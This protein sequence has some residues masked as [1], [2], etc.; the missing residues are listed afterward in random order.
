[1]AEVMW[2]TGSGSYSEYEECV[3]KLYD[4]YMDEAGKITEAYMNS[5]QQVLL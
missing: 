2:Y 5:A 1:M 4:V 3:A